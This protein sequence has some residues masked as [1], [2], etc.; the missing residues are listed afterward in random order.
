[1]KL[2][3]KM[4]ATFALVGVAGAAIAQH[5]GHHSSGGHD[6]YQSRSYGHGSYNSRSYDY[7]H[8]DRRSSYN[9]GRRDDRDYGYPYNSHRNDH[10]SI[11]LGPL[12]IDQGGGRR[13]YGYSAGHRGSRRHGH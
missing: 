7:G 11:R 12:H 3:V 9:Y 4:L 8:Y 13:G 6:Y 1:M 5:H 2:A 10:V